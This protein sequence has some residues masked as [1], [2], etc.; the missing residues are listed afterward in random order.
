MPKAVIRNFNDQRG[1]QIGASFR[2]KPYEFTFE[3]MLIP[4]VTGVNVE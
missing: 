4:S 2:L 3:M 1:K